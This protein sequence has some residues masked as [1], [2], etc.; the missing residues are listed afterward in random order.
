MTVEEEITDNGR[1]YRA[2]PARIERPA[3]EDELRRT[4]VAAQREGRKLVV[5]G[6]GKSQGGLFL[7][8]G[9]VMVDMGAFNQIVDIDPVLGTA[10][11][12]SGVTWDDLRRAVNSYGLAPA[13]SQSY[14]VFSIGGSVSVNAH[15]RNV[16]SGVLATTILSLRVM[17]SDGTVVDASRRH[18]AELF[19]LV[20]GGFGL[21]GIVLDV[22]L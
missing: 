1:H 12:Q 17:L 6:A 10:R 22:T 7:C 11:V 21:F 8:D 16:D 3:N 9:A 4:L 20:I 14:L 13:S 5:R 19:S 15:G 18:Q 2:R